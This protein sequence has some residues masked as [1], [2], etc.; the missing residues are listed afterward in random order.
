[1]NQR[2]QTVDKQRQPIGRRSSGSGR[3]TFVMA[4]TAAMVFAALGLVHTWTRVAVFDR[5]YQQSRA[6]GENEKLA[7]EATLNGQAEGEIPAGSVTMLRLGAGATVGVLLPYSRLQESEA[8][9]L[10]LIYM[11]KAGYDPRMAVGF[12]RRMSEA[13]KGAAKPPEFLSTHPTDETRIRQ[14]EAWLPEALSYYKQK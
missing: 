1:M 7:R 2:R 5:L 10:G 11:A 9:R 6:R 14:I 13:A 8:D 3:H 4:V 12:W